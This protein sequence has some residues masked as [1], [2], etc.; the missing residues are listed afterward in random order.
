MKIYL[1]I[2]EYVLRFEAPAVQ[3]TLLEISFY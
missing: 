1:S 2:Y 3:Q